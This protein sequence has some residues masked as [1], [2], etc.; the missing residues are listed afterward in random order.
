MVQVQESRQDNLL[1]YHRGPD[2]G[3]LSWHTPASTPLRADGACE[4]AGPAEAKLLDLHD[5]RAPTGHP[6][7]VLESI[8]IQH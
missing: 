6:R 5:Y 2:P 4:G 3:L 7:R 8:W 1:S